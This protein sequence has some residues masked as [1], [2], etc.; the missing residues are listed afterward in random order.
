LG[1]FHWWFDQTGRGFH[2]WVHDEPHPP[3]GDE[4][5]AYRTVRV[6]HDAGTGGNKVAIRHEGRWQQVGGTRHFHKLFSAIEL[7][8]DCWTAGV[9]L[10]A[11]FRSCRLYPH[12]ARDPVTVFVGNPKPIPEAAVTLRG[13]ASSEILS[14]DRVDADGLAR[15]RLPQDLRFPIAATFVVRNR[16]SLLDTWTIQA[17]GVSGVYPGDVYA[18]PCGWQANTVW[19]GHPYD[20]VP[21]RRRPQPQ[22]AGPVCR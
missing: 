8:V 20:A 19:P 10:D 4:A 3:F 2:K 7:K 11:R 22:G 5:S 15:L 9:E 18:A 16:D 17:S 6:S 12:P 21:L 13:S 14:Q 1:W